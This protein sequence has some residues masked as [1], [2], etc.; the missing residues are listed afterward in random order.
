[1][2]QIDSYNEWYVVC[3]GMTNDELG[4]LLARV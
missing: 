2:E 1:M 4:L 3:T